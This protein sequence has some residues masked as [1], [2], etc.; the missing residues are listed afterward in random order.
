MP[1]L[2]VLFIFWIVG[3]ENMQKNSILR[4]RWP[5]ERDAEWICIFWFAFLFGVRQILS[6]G[7]GR[8]LEFASLKE[9]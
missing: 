4:V 5:G 2:A 3:V 6:V 9:H 1:G 7:D 8:E